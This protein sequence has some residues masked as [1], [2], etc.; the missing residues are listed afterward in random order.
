MEKKTLKS[1]KTI[2]LLDNSEIDYV[3]VEEYVEE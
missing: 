3:K 1:S 2:N